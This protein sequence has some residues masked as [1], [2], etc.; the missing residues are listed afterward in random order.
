MK[1]RYMLLNSLNTKLLGFEDIKSMYENDIDFSSIYELCDK[2]VVDKCYRHEGYLFR[3]NKLCTPNCSIGE[4]LVRK[5]HSG[6]LMGA[7]H[8]T[9]SF[10][11]F[12]IAYGFNPLTF[13]DLLP[14]PVN[15]RGS[16]NGKRKAVLVKS[17]HEKVKI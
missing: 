1:S 5:A 6:G 12:E 11:P 10:S 7:V 2:R 8:S 17:L 15:E 9:T 3:E 16:L 13:L 14:L 4:L